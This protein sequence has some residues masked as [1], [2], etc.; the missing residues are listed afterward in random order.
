MYSGVLTNARLEKKVAQVVAGRIQWKDMVTFNVCGILRM[1]SS[2]L[3]KL[4]D[5]HL[6]DITAAKEALIAKP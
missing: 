5:T 2:P 3:T 6:P 1:F 4:S